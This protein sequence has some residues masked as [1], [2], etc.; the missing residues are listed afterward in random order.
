MAI[1][2]AMVNSLYIVLWS[3]LISSLVTWYIC[4]G[5]KA[6]Q[7]QCCGAWRKNKIDT[8]FSLWNA[9]VAIWAQAYCYAYNSFLE[10]NALERYDRRELLLIYKFKTT[11]SIKKKISLSFVFGFNFLFLSSSLKKKREKKK[12]LYPAHGC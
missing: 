1:D 12:K 5:N 2:I 7:R 8:S 10:L 11:F 4:A 3:L 6:L 9:P